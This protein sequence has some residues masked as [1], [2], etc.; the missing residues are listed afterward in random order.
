MANSKT[1][2]SCGT[3]NENPVDNT[4]SICGNGLDFVPNEGST[5]SAVKVKNTIQGRRTSNSPVTSIDS[6]GKIIVAA[7]FL[8]VAFLPWVTIFN[9]GV[10]ILEIASMDKIALLFLIV[11]MLPVYTKTPNSSL[12]DG[13]L[14]VATLIIL[15]RARMIGGSGAAGLGIGWFLSLVLVGIIG[16][17]NHG[18]IFSQD[19]DPVAS[20]LKPEDSTPM[21]KGSGDRIKELQQLLDDGVINENEFAEKKKQILGDL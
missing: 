1:C 5:A 19:T 6:T 4:C 14:V 8:G 15:N 16:A 3:L 10:N 2:K 12:N 13:S 18:S 21:A 20:D 7:L 9:R 11:G 17:T